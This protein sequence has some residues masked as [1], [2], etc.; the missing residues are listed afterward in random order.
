MIMKRMTNHLSAAILFFVALAMF[1]SCK[2]DESK[3]NDTAR[4]E[5]RLTD[6]PDPNVKEVW[7][8]IKDIKVHVN[9]SSENGWTRLT[10]F[11]PG[12]YNLL[13]LTNGK[14]TL[15]VDSEIP[16]GKLSQIRLIL[17]DN[18]YIIT[19]DGQKIFLTTPSAQ[20]SGLKLNLHQDVTGGLL[21]R[22]VLDFDAARSIVKAGSTGKYNLKPV[23]RVLSFVPS[24]GIV[25]GV[26]APDSVKT[27]IYA[28]MGID[29]IASTYSGI[30]GNYI[31]RDIP[32]GTYSIHFVPNDSTFNP[33]V[34]TPVLVTLGQT[35]VV[36]TVKLI[37]N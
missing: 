4:L 15:L 28:L 5:I 37:K 36:D 2:K 34:K 17:G 8:D 25:K 30:G 35:T 20:E 11:Y 6:A 26:V 12:V 33:S 10:H 19:K 9:D 29:T 14:D 1:A 7:V 13:D 23:I 31:L 22:L 24:G 16:A 3:N 27:T 32:A 18:N 21:Y